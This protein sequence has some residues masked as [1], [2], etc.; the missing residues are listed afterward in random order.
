M[1]MIE[2]LRMDK[3]VVSIGT[4]NEQGDD[5][6]YWA[7]RTP[8]ERL[9]ALEFMRQVMYSYDPETSRLERVFTIG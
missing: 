7:S 3:S 8:A 5:R 9:Q 4:L 2:T 1:S 6:E